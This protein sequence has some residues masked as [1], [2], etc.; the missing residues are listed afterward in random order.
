MTA[1]CPWHGGPN[2]RAQGAFLPTTRSPAA[3][4]QLVAPRTMR[5]FRIGA[6]GGFRPDH[7][8]A[9]SPT[10]ATAAPLTTPARGAPSPG[11]LLPIFVSFFGHLRDHASSLAHHLN[12][13]EQASF[14]P[15]LGLGLG[16]HVREPDAGDATSRAADARAGSGGAA[17]RLLHHVQQRPPPHQE[18]KEPQQQQPHEDDGHFWVGPLLA[19]LPWSHHG[20]PFSS[21]DSPGPGSSTSGR[22]PPVASST[23]PPPPPSSSSSSSPQ[24]LDDPSDLHHRLAARTVGLSVLWR[25]ALALQ[26][27]TLMTAL[28]RMGQAMEAADKARRNMPPPAEVPA[29]VHWG[30]VAAAARA[31]ETV[32]LALARTAIAASAAAAGVPAAAAAV[33]GSAA[34]AAA[35]AAVAAPHLP[36]L[37]HARRRLLAAATPTLE[38][39]CGLQRGCTTHVL[40]RFLLFSAINPR[41]RRDLRVR[42]DVLARRAAQVALLQEQ[43]DAWLARQPAGPRAASPIQVP[44]AA[45][46]GSAATPLSARWYRRV[47][48][49]EMLACARQ[50][51]LEAPGSPPDDRAAGDP[52]GRFDLRDLYRLIRVIEVAVED[53]EHYE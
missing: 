9:S 52:P 29:L 24:H 38:R 36:L 21:K 47:F 1:T 3:R 45:G 6:S 26:Q 15:S 50:L 4:S 22:A 44:S 13:A 12:S 46:G 35:A 10:D 41:M 39:L 37:R 7:V 48:A 14:L 31:E 25:S 2:K 8:G 5:S 34:A 51:Q 19:H 16:P 32:A 53:L 17:W 23:S 27:R 11:V 18:L 33:T 49:P 43:H 30:A 20:G 28:W 42:L 40:L